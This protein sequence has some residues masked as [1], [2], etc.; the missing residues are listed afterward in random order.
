[1][2]KSR[3]LVVE[4]DAII[5]K[6]IELS[7]VSLGYDV[8]ASAQTGLEAVAKAEKHQPDITLMDIRLKGEMDGIEA[9]DNI[10]SRFNLPVI[11]LT[12]FAEEERLERAKLTL[13]YGYLVKPVQDKD[14]KITI[15]MALYAAK[16]E[17]ERRQ[18][19]DALKKREKD[20]GQLVENLSTGILIHKKNR[21]IYQNPECKK[22]IGA[23][24]DSEMERFYEV[25]IDENRKTV[26]DA[27][28]KLLSGETRT[29]NL[30]FR[31]LC[32]LEEENEVLEKWVQSL[33]SVI[34][35]KDEDALL[36]NLIDITK[37][38]EMEKHFDIQEKMSS[39]GRISAG[40]A[41][42]IR[43]PLTGI[44]SYLYSLQ[45]FLNEDNF[46]VENLPMARQII[47][48]I[49]SA[50]HMIESVIKR[51][52]DFSKMSTP[53]F[54]P[55][56][57]NKAVN[58]AI[59]LSLTSLRKAGIKL[60]VS[61]AEGPLQCFADPQLIK[62]VALNLINNAAQ[63]LE[64]NKTEKIIK[65][66]TSAINKNIII[67]IVDSG[68][69]VKQEI[70]QKIFDPFFSTRKDGSGIGLSIVQRI[71]TD[72]QG[73]ISVSENRYGGAT[74]QIELPVEKRSVR[75]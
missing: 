20:F 51:V 18:A 4:D 31:L 54:R 45:N 56:D 7:L 12:A 41:H 42:E 47:E 74:F 68:P 37:T 32:K 48:Q 28:N 35:Y 10:R 36:I 71:V 62:Q 22:I 75:P 11:F 40:I 60:Q 58:E 67:A 70:R 5:Y 73:I 1:M 69:G 6:E 27:F 46:E 29:S 61:L 38:R 52:I 63:A 2:A 57:A 25:I 49:K 55:T 64:E 3:I 50:S 30:K 21:I 23:L 39:L 8:V 66:S 13:P 14:L 16:I 59:E 43:N 33:A 9:A 72:H 53:K 24:T 34:K 15:E 44:N 19:E 17:S 65:I 26:I